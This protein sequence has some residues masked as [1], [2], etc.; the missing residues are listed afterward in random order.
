MT[1]TTIGHTV[2]RNFLECQ[3]DE[4]NMRADELLLLGVISSLGGK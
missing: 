2:R 4:L 3:M 1:M